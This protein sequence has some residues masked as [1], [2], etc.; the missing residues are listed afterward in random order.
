MCVI[1]LKVSDA[2]YKNV[3]EL[4]Q[5]YARPLL[6][7]SLENMGQE[8]D[9][10]SWEHLRDI[11]LPLVDANHAT[12]LIGQDNPD[13]LIP[14]DARRGKVGKPYATKTLFGWT[15]NG[16]LG[17]IRRNSASVNFIQVDHNL[18]AQIEEF[19]KVEYPETLLTAKRGSSYDD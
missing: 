15:L 4:P 3:L 19:W 7:V 13:A 12:L 2:E 11:N 16:P 14:F 17:G 6:P 18:N 8:E 5:V 1:S 10:S 9:A